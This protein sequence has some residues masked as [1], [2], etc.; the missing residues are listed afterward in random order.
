MGEIEGPAETIDRDA[1]D[2]DEIEIVIA[3]AQIER[4]KAAGES[5]L[6]DGHAGE[7][8]EQVDG[9]RQVALADLFTGDDAG[10]A[11]LLAGRD[12]DGGA[13]HAHRILERRQFQ[14]HEQ[15]LRCGGESDFGGAESGRGNHEFGI[16][17]IGN[18]GIELERA[19]DTGQRAGGDSGGDRHSDL[20]AHD[21][22]AGRI[23]NRAFQRS[24]RKAGGKEQEQGR[25]ALETYIHSRLLPREPK[26][27]N[28]AGRSPGLRIVE[29]PSLP[30]P[31]L[32]Q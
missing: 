8:A 28:L 21:G 31:S 3:A 6:A 32:E 15:G 18:S 13:D 25:K 26:V 12:I 16:G 9:L 11:A 19:V 22:S 20:G 24:S 27:N 29:S 1:V 17:R 2:L 5:G 10:A 4:G 30:I 7:K 14:L 23:G